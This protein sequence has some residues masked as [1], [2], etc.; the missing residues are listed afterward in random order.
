[1]KIIILILLILI[2][3]GCSNELTCTLKGE[4]DTKVIINYNNKVKSINSNLIFK[5]NEEAENYCILL[6]L[7]ENSLDFEC[8]KNKI[9][10]SDYKEYMQIKSDNL[11]DIK[12]QL[13][14]QG[15][16]CE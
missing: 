11:K 12:E 14:S 15:F 2:S 9:I 4:F 6:T 10:I 5:T 7:S 13:I 3:S 1:M 8:I 16:V